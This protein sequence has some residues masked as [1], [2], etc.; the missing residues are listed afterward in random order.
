[1]EKG[2]IKKYGNWPRTKNGRP[3]FKSTE[4]ANFY[5]QLIWDM[6]DEQKWLLICRDDLYVKL[7]HERERPEPNFQV[8]MNTACQAQFLRECV[9]ECQRIKDEKFKV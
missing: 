6:D 4:D 9:E 2:Y 7:R 8:M 3:V 1:M 5:A